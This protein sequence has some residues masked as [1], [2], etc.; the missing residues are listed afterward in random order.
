MSP[1][2]EGLAI[3]QSP[4]MT[5]SLSAPASSLTD[6]MSIDIP[7]S[8]AISR[9]HQSNP[10]P[11]PEQ[12]PKDANHLA[13][14]LPRSPLSRSQSS[15]ES[16]STGSSSSDMFALPPPVPDKDEPQR[17]SPLPVN[18]PP[19]VP[20]LV[21]PVTEPARTGLGSRC[22]VH[23]VK[24]RLMGMYLSVYIYKG[25]ESLVQGELPLW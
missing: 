9:P 24:E 10:I 23:L 5:R 17:T 1:Q 7:S 18:P 25:C 6:P 20:G 13:P 19:D 21:I 16:S 11:V 2:A 12:H 3:P 22:Y 4:S 8:S 15:L 14:L